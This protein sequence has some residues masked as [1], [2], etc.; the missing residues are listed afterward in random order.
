MPQHA[1]RALPLCIC[2]AAWLF[3]ASLAHCAIAADKWPELPSKNGKATIPAQEWPQ[4]PGGRTVPIEIYFPGGE[5]AKVNSE[6]GIFLTLHN[7][8]GKGAQG[9]ADPKVLADRYNV[10]AITVDYLQ[11][12]P[13]N[14]AT[15]PYDFG[16]LQALDALRALYFVYHHLQSAGVPFDSGRIFAVGGSG[17]G[18]VT[19][20]CNKLAPRTF[21]GIVDLSGMAKLSDDIAYNLPGGS[22]LNARY[23]RDPD[24]PNY[25]SADAQQLRFVGDPDHLQTMRF[26][27]N[28]SKIVVIHGLDDTTC[29][30]EDAQEMVRN[31]KAAGLDV[32]PH[33]I[34]QSQIDGKV[35]K[36]TGHSLGNRTLI[37]Q[38]LAD[39]YFTPGDPKALRRS[40]KTDFDHRDELVRYRTPS[41]HFIISYADGYPVGR[42]E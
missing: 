20:M 41:G 30:A 17:G 19:L 2:L 31:M 9:T 33:F 3:A 14:G 11:S 1:I 42:F 13:A 28:A 5:L 36:N 34:D 10:I 25:L 24:S 18:N 37:L 6:T 22:S 38:K 35:I 8:S 39:H 40:G 21:A 27:G 23:S 15:E 29:P 26:L 4:R 12:G 7:W 16:Y 32:E